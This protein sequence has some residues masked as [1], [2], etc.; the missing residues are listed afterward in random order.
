MNWPS[1]FLCWLIFM[2]MHTSAQVHSADRVMQLSGDVGGAIY[3]TSGVYKNTSTSTSVLPYLYAENDYI[4]SRVDT[5]GVKLLPLGE[6]QLEVVA[7]YSLE[8]YY[9]GRQTIPLNI[10]QRNNPQP[11]GIGTFQTYEWGAI[12][13][14]ALKDLVSLG[15]TEEITYALEF[16][17][18]PLTFYPQFGLERRSKKYITHLYGV[19]DAESLASGLPAYA[20]TASVS[21][22]LGLA[23]EM[24]LGKN[25]VAIYQY[26][27]RRLDSAITNSPLVGAH[28]NQSLQF[29]ALAYR[30]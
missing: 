21:G 7:R 9:P 25:L 8:G 4:F 3:Q 2:P 17:S 1:L 5:F 28:H 11:V 13:F 29:L 12:F 26:K 27:M 19:T 14:Y 10:A 6:G 18:G 24:S 22:T 16:K 23:A 20:P 30:L 15:D